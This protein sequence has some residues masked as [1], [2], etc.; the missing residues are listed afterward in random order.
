MS[1]T[2]IVTGDNAQ[3]PG[4]SAVA[5]RPDQLI[6]DSRTLVSDKVVL[7]AGTYKRGQV[8]G[9]VSV[10][11][12]EGVPGPAN[13]GNG[14]IGALSTKSLN[15]GAY[16]VTATDATHFHVVSPE[17]VDLG[18]ATV[19]IA[20]VSAEIGFTLSA[21]ATAFAANDLFT[22]TAFDAAGIYVPSVRTASDGSQD[23]SAIL[24]D[25]VTL[26]VPGHVGAYFAGEF[27]LNALSYDA[28]WTP[29][30]L[31]AS[32]RKHGIYAKTSISAAAPLNNSA[33]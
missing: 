9:L 33:P 30:L 8:V 15:T 27:N 29:S 18:V 25:D 17:G 24:A 16:T 20:F 23:A 32:L 14:S 11:A 7:A 19:G 22:V 28:S 5:Y 21:G 13:V 26:A 31:A 3:L 4:I 2:P 6:A 12:L 10:N 1:L